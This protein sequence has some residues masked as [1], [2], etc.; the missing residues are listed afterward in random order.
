MGFGQD[1][2]SGSGRVRFG[3]I[4]PGGLVVREVPLR[5]R[6]I[7]PMLIV[8]GV[9]MAGFGVL[10]LAW[11]Q[12][13]AVVLVSIFGVYAL[14]D[15]LTTIG[16]GLTSRRGG[17]GGRGWLLQG[18]L[19]VLAG[20]LA[21]A[22]PEAT[23]V[24]VLLIIGL[25]ALFL[26]VVVLGIGLSVRRFNRRV[27]VVPIVLGAIGVIFGLVLLFNPAE[28]VL[29]LIAVLGVVMLLGGGLLIYG[30]VRLRRLQLT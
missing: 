1:F 6:R 23:A 21:L 29:G 13:S 7:W 17:F 11:P 22:W 10:A 24:V 3:S 9:L 25:W 5:V 4:T 19:A 26:G 27:A 16:Y 30:G 20:V 28:S 12:L 18:S 2:G 8:R 15:G 14:L